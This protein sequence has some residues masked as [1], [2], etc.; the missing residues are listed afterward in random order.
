MTVESSRL[1]FKSPP[2]NLTCLLILVAPYLAGVKGWMG[3]VHCQWTGLPHL[4]VMSHISSA[5]LHLFPPLLF[6]SL[7]T[8]F[9]LVTRTAIHSAPTLFFL[10]GPFRFMSDEPMP[11]CPMRYF[12]ALV[13][14]C[15][16]CRKHLCNRQK[17]V[18]NSAWGEPWVNGRQQ[19][20]GYLFSPPPAGGLFGQAVLQLLKRE[21]CKTEQ[22]VK[23]TRS[24]QM[25]SAPSCPSLLLSASLSG[26]P[27]RSD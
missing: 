5:L 18:I 10:T 23:K 16:R 27:G 13:S 4:I 3:P 21:S 19:Q 22:L 7:A 6:T 20:V 17:Q 12:G 1:V 8:C 25:R 24:G 11:P 9:T 26:S 15:C 2:W 14:Y